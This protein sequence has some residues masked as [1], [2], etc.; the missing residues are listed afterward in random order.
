MVKR[1]I[2]QFKVPEVKAIPVPK[3]NKHPLPKYTPILP[4]HEFTWV[5]ITI[6]L[7]YLI[8]SYITQRCRQDYIH[9]KYVGVVQ[10]VF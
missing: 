8:G 7:T 6:K 4:Y 10:G 5:R 9:Y 3:G 1:K 2:A